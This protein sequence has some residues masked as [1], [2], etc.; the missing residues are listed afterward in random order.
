MHFLFCL[1]F[2]VFY[3]GQSALTFEEENW[4]LDLHEG[5]IQLNNVQKD[6]LRFFGDPTTSLGARGLTS[7][8]TKLWSN[9]IVPYD[10]SLELENVPEA[11]ASINAAIREWEENTCLKFVRRTTERDYIKM[12]NGSGCWSYVGRQGGM[13]LMSLKSGCWHLGTVAH[14]IGHAMGFWHEQSRPDRDNF[15]KIVWD[16]IPE[17]RRHNFNKY[18][19]TQ[20]DSLGVRYDYLAIMHYSKTAFSSNGQPT[21]IP[22]DPNAIQLGQRVGLSPLDVKQADL[23]YKCNGQTTRPLTP[24]KPNPP[25]PGPDTCTFDIMGDLCGFVNIDGD[26][27]DWTQ[28]L[29]KTPSGK[30]G[31]AADHTTG[32]WGW[33]LYIE[34]SI[35]RKEGDTAI[36]RSKAYASTTERCLHFYYHMYGKNIGSLS[37]THSLISDPANEQELWKMLGNQGNAWIRADVQLP[38]TSSPYTISF[39]GVRGNGYMGDI[40]IDDIYFTDGRC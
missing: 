1:A 7:D 29:G 36:L 4:L 32:R 13:Q 38:A 21:I 20:V 14:E 34:A 11:V 9:L 12:F 18:N 28:L 16:N 30:T 39:V 19:R 8:A 17:P 10:I 2:V 27:F 6:S 23:L 40:A 25:P 31:P 33:F 37:V 15:V 35:P 24:I 26:Q 3:H 22:L 5:D